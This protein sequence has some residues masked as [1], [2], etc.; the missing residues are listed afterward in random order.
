MHTRKVC[1][2]KPCA[3]YVQTQYSNLVKVILLLIIRDRLSSICCKMVDSIS[4][5]RSVVNTNLQYKYT[6]P[7]QVT[8]C[9]TCWMCN[10]MFV[11]LKL[12]M[13]SF[14]LCIEVL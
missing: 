5:S 4:V 11:T 8:L 7:D 3:H 1:Q 12:I 6:V 2:E 10:A 13:P 14:I 9:L